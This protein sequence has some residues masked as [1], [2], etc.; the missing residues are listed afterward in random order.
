MAAATGDTFV[1]VYAGWLYRERNPEPIFRAV[2]RLIDEGCIDPFRIRIDLVGWCDAAQGE[3]VKAVAARSGL[4][5]SVRMEGPFSKAETFR[6]ISQANLLL[7]LAEGWELRVP[8][9]AYEYLR[10]GRPILALAPPDSAIGDLFRKTGGGHV[11]D[12]TDDAAITAA[13]RAEYTAW[14]QRTP[15]Q[16]ADPA[17]VAEF[18]RA[19]LMGRLA[20]VFE[21]TAH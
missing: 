6:R 17:S 19:A 11:V 15:P 10:A 13:I 4:E 3:S 7:M 5:G 21:R 16:T 14:A 12:H 2:R 18:D 9:K 8:A 20:A 1:I